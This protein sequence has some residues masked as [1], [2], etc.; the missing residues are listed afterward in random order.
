MKHLAK[1]APLAAIKRHPESLL[2]G[3]AGFLVPVLPEACETGTRAYHKN[4]WDHW[5]KNRERFALEEPRGFNW[6]ASNIRPANHPQRRLAALAQI[7][8]MWDEFKNLCRLETRN[9][10]IRF[11]ISLEHPYWNLHVTLPSHLLAK[12][13]RLIGR[14]RALDFIVNHV[15]ALDESEQAWQ[16]YLDLPGSTPGTAITQTA[17]SLLER[18]DRVARFTRKAFMQQAFLQIHHDFCSGTCRRD[19]LLPTQSFKC[20]A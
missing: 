17:S 16:L 6:I 10:L 19:C 8:G 12:P 1:R 18:A 11:M 4:L 14:D 7:V 5:W 2:F 9:S 13:V 15:A 20:E 3:T